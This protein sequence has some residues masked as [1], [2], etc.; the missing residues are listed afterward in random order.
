M[1]Q[2]GFSAN[3]RPPFGLD[4]VVRDPANLAN[5]I[6]GRSLGRVLQEMPATVARKAMT[7][8]ALPGAVDR[9][10]GANVFL[11]TLSDLLIASTIDKLPL[12][13][14]KARRFGAVIMASTLEAVADGYGHRYDRN[15]FLADVEARMAHLE[16]TDASEYRGADRP[17]VML[18]A[19]QLRIDPWSAVE[20]FEYQVS[21]QT[22]Y[23]KLKKAA[24]HAVGLLQRIGRPEAEYASERFTPYQG[25]SARYLTSE[26]AAIN[27]LVSESPFAQRLAQLVPTEKPSSPELSP[28]ALYAEGVRRTAAF[29]GCAVAHM[30]SS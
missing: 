22:Q 8:T 11:S 13:Q 17:L 14:K 18:Q 12:T 3:K 26:A 2:A 7:E 27:Q 4:V 20:D 24:T 28:Q 15:A 23:T 30:A 6:Q 29:L 5:T 21:Q 25:P 9:I 19:L 1:S 16:Q 10:L